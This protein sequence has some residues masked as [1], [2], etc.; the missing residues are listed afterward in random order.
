MAG[1][2]GRGLRRE[3][4]GRKIRL[5]SRDKNEIEAESS[6]ERREKQHI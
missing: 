6:K 4:E 2:T 5:D 3:K 1:N